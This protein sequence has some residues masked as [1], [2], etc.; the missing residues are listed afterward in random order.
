MR[1]VDIGTCKK[2]MFVF[3]KNV[4]C[5]QSA[6]GIFLIVGIKCTMLAFVVVVFALSQQYQKCQLRTA[7]LLNIRHTKI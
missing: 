6:V 5:S 3:N 2:L 1:L 4:L 7:Q